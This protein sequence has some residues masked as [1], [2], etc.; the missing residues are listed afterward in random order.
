MTSLL[1]LA[2]C[3]ANVPVYLLVGRKI[4]GTW[5][6]FTDTVRLW[7][8]LG[9]LNGPGGVTPDDIEADTRLGIFL[10][11]CFGVVLAE[12]LLL[13]GVLSSG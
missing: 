4:F 3:M 6:C 9:L 5:D 7:A 1:L 13:G 2:L 10:A 11:C 12:F 8:S